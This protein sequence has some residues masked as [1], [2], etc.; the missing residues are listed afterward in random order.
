MEYNNFSTEQL[1]ETSKCGNFDQNHLLTLIY[2]ILCGVN[3]IHSSGLIHD[4][5]KPSTINLD[6]S[7]FVTVSSIDT[8]RMP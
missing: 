6:E 5:L 1:L 2:N 4:N 7:C 8:V 3:F